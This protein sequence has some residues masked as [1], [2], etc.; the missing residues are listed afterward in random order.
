[1]L[2]TKRRP[3]RQIGESQRFQRSTMKKTAVGPLLAVLVIVV[4]AAVYGYM[5]YQVNRQAKTMDTLTTTIVTDTQTVSGLVN[6]INASLAE[7]QK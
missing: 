5:T 2:T 1:M 3:S 7:T 4:L 6:F